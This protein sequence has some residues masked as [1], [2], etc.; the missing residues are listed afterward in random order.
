[1]WASTSALT[2]LS[3]ALLTALGRSRHQSRFGQGALAKAFFV[4]GTSIAKRELNHTSHFA[5]K[6]LAR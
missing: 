2:L 1:M 4:R 5:A 6:N 3:R